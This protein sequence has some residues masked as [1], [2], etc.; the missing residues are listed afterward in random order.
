MQISGQLRRAALRVLDGLDQHGDGFLRRGQRDCGQGGTTDGL[1]TGGQ[2][3]V[4]G[5]IDV[6]PLI[7]FALQGGML[8]E[9]PKEGTRI[10]VQMLAQLGGGEPAG[11]L[12]DQG[13]DGLRQMAMA[14]KADI[15]MEP[16]PLLIELGQ[17]GQSIEAAIVIEAGQSAPHFEPPTDGAERALELFLEFGQ[18][19]DLLSPPA[20]EQRGDRILDRFHGEGGIGII[21]TLYDC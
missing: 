4:S 3:R 12:E 2:G 21:G 15:A 5:E 17:L 7:F 1:L 9:L 19:D 18:G 13:D 11:R 14:G 8:M 6:V 16:K 20:P 10:Q